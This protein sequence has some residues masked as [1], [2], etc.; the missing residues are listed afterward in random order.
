MNR[1]AEVLEMPRGGESDA[2]TARRIA[3]GRSVV[4]RYAERL[5]IATD[6]LDPPTASEVYCAL[7]E[8]HE[9]L[10]EN[11]SAQVESDYRKAQELFP[12]SH[13]ANMGLRRLSRVQRDYGAVLASLDCEL[14]GATRPE[15]RHALQLELA[16]TYLYCECDAEKTISILEM[17]EDDEGDASTYTSETNAFDPEVFLLWEDALLATGAWD[18]YV[19]KL[20]EALKQQSETGM[21]TQH[22]EERLWLLYRYLMP[23]AQQAALL[24]HHLMRHQPLDDELADDALMRAVLEAS[25]D[26][27]VDILTKAVERLVG[28]PRADFYRALLADVAAF[29]FDDPD[30]AI[31][32]LSDMPSASNDL[33]LLHPL[34][35]L[36][37]DSGR[38][39]DMLSVVVRCLESLN[40]P[41]QKA[42]QLYAIACIMRD[43]IENEDAAFDVLREAIDTYPSHSPT[44]EALAEIYTQNAEWENLV[45]LY[46]LELSYAIEHQLPEYTPELFT[47]RHARLAQLYEQLGFALN[48]FNHYKAMLALKPDDIAALKG[49]ILIAMEESFEG[50]VE[51]GVEFLV[52]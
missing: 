51:W 3:Q 4:E 22:I 14:Q 5:D 18:R 36:L 27:R 23:D 42:E 41:Q 38:V 21:M 19:G 50:L 10:I 9:G 33:F 30:H 8:L 37:S 20:R 13:T 7:G 45:Q 49:A 2:V 32:V 35:E 46:E 31:D 16:R 40:A 17:L 15:N 28:S 44:V 29:D 1:E 26:E 48:A 25:K 52:K 24:S 39:E 11:D 6:H 43:D 12:Q 34:I 47:I